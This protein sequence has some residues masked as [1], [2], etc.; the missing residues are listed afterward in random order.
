M[1]PYIFLIGIAA[2]FTDQLT[3]EYIIEHS[4]PIVNGIVYAFSGL[5]SMHLC[6]KGYQKRTVFKN[7][8]AMHIT[9]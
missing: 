9:L 7:R 1:L 4:S 5:V 8:I 3:S 2:L 6:Y